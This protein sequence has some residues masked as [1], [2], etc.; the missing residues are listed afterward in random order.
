ML[1]KITNWGLTSI[2]MCV[3][4]S[5]RD[6]NNLLVIKI[7]NYNLFGIAVIDLAVVDLKNE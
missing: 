3:K 7:N 4:L 6:L 1:V 2:L 5:L